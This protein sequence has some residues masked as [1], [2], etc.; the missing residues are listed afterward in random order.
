MKFKVGIQR[1]L[2]FEDEIVVDAY[3]ETELD[4]AIRKLEIEGN[5][6]DDVNTLFNNNFLKIVDSVED[7]SGRCEFECTFSEECED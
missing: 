1:T 5:H 2:I 3:N 7:D 4:K 6:P